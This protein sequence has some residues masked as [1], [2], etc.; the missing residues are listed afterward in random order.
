[1]NMTGKATVDVAKEKN[2]KMKGE[3]TLPNGVRIRV[4]GVAASLIDAVTSR[5][6]EPEIPMAYIQDKER[7]EPNPSDPKY[8]KELEE[9]G[10]KRGIAAIDA[11]VMFGIDL[12]DGIPKDRSWLS[13]LKFMQKHGQLDLS[14]YDLEDEVDLEF[15]Y[16]RFV[17]ADNYIITMLSE[18]SG[19][20]PEDEAKAVES[21]QGS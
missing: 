14:E 18:A 6:R 11:M 4:N 17:L 12:L 1:M 16:K 5:I 10:R 3:V 2:G 13:K 15:L 7:E 19:L 8:Q 20:T 9:I 21:F